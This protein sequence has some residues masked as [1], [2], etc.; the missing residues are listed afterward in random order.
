MSIK[1]ASLVD[2]IPIADILQIVIYFKDTLQNMGSSCQRYVKKRTL[3]ILIEKIEM[4]VMVVV[5]VKEDMMIMVLVVVE[6]DIKD[7]LARGTTAGITAP[8]KYKVRT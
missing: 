4:V 3:A 7:V 2:P 5:V 1:V 8:M 6:G